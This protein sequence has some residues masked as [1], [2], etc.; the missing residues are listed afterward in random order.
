[1]SEWDIIYEHV[2][3]LDPRYSISDERVWVYKLYTDWSDQGVKDMGNLT[4]KLD[5]EHNSDLPD[6]LFEISTISTIPLYELHYKHVWYLDPEYAKYYNEDDEK[7]WVT[8]ICADKNPAGIKDMG[9]LTPKLDIKYN[10]DLQDITCD[11]PAVPLYN[12]HYKHVWYLDPNYSKTDEKIWVASICTSETPAGVKDMG[13]IK[14]NIDT[15]LD[16]IFISYNE[17]NAEENWQRVLSKAPTAMRVNGVK[18]IFEAHKSAAELATTDMFYVVDGDAY[19]ADD[20][21]FTFSPTVFDRDCVFVFNSQN[22]INGLVYGYGGVKIFP[23]KLLLEATDWS[24]DMTTSI[25]KKLKVIDRISNIA[26]FNTDEFATWRSAFRECVKLAAE[27]IDNQ[28]SKETQQRLDT[29]VTVGNKQPFSLYA[30]LGARAGYKYGVDYRDNI[31]MLKKINNRDWLSE[32]FKLE[33]IRHTR[34][35]ISH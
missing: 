7:I 14:P 25:G 19:L 5:I 35:E 3:C 27:I 1:M 4:P 24:V 15:D 10:P 32:Q 28:D 30:K 26:V 29:W 18:G 22:P 6:L 8:S 31:E 9:Y 12:L 16:V 13:Y 34:N 21:E 33:M 2:W 11:L 23:R 20:W 17:P